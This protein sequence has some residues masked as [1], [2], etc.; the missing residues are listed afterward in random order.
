M[1]SVFWKNVL[2]QLEDWKSYVSSEKD[3]EKALLRFTIS[4]LLEFL[5]E[6]LETYFPEEM[7]I[8]PPISTNIKTGSIVRNASKN[9]YVV[10]SP[11]CDLA[12]HD[13]NI[14]TDRILVCFIEK[15]T[16]SKAQ[17]AFNSEIVED[18]SEKQKA[19]KG[20]EKDRAERLL[21]RLPGNNFSNYYHYLPQTSRFTGGVINFRKV[22]TLKP[23]DFKK[24]FGEPI[25]QISMA[26]TKDIVARFSSYY[27]RQGQPDFDDT[28][29]DDLKK[30]A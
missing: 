13:G 23:S 29:L 19:K 4:H 2:P 26:F 15:N 25:I 14:K 7:Y 12:V 8:S 17:K 1:D 22:R 30:A 5:D 9:Y 11:A 24:E 27:A 16:I 18:D 20:K 6:D 28:V 3:N 21:T 10:L